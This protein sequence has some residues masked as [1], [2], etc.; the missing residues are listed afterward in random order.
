MPTIIQ[1]E[2]TGIL[3]LPK[4]AMRNRG[5]WTQQDSDVLA[6]FLQV[7]AQIANSKWN[8][9]DVR[10]TTQGDQLL[11]HSFPE[12]E[13]FVFA[14]VYLRQLIAK[15]DSLL[16]E[17]VDRYC[18]FVDC[19]LRAAWV[20][21]E[22][23]QFKAELNGTAFL[24]SNY[25]VRELF[26]AFMY[27]AALLHKV[28]DAGNSNRIKFIELYDTQPRHKLL[29][30]FHTSLKMLMNH[31]SGVAIVIYRDYSHWSHD[32]NLPAPDIR[33]HNKLFDIVPS[34]AK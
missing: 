14:A 24:L 15:D 33:W 12:F 5:D 6:H 30:A 27:G 9:A 32:Y 13:D 8:K 25:T 11:D 3:K 7:Q 21:C 1:G 19:A 31:V 18:R 16:Q 2:V 10:Y 22:G 20:H 23:A 28:R 4:A 26:D 17:V 34:Q 29:Y